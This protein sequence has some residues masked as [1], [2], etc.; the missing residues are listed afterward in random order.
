M[1]QLQSRGCL[2]FKDA[3]QI[4]QVANGTPVW[5]LGCGAG[6]TVDAVRQ[7]CNAD[8]DS[9]IALSKQVSAR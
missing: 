5:V 6:I 7:W 2:Y 8:A 9:Y 3:V 1:V 4:S